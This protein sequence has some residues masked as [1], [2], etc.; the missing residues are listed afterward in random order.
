MFTSLFFFIT[1]ITIISHTF[2]FWKA[3]SHNHIVC[4]LPDDVEEMFV[5]VNDGTNE[6]IKHKTLPIM[7]VQFHPE[8]SPGPKET[9]WV[10]DRFLET[11]SK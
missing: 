1:F 4:D 8:A 5:N 11:V 7:S 2:I 3:Q 10:F 6:G 9:G